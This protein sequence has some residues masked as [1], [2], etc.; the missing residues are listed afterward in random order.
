[1]PVNLAQYRGL[2]RTITIREIISHNRSN[3][4]SGINL[5]QFL[6][7]ELLINISKTLFSPA[8][9]KEWNILDSDIRSSES[10]NVFKI[11]VLKFM[12]PK[13]NFFFNWLNPKGV[14]LITRLRLLLIHL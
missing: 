13:A 11:K 4:Y 2:V 5:Q 6:S 10:L 3:L 7:V 8:S 9:I 12:R 14:K 1:M